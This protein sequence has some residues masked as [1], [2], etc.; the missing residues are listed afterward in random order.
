MWSSILHDK[1][2][3]ITYKEFAKYGFLVM[4]WVI[5]LACLTLALE[6]LLWGH[7]V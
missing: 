3:Q 4:P 2:I 5:T 1:D 7:A 6:H